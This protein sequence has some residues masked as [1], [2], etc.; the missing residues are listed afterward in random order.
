[1]Q[2]N[3]RAVYRWDSTHQIGPVRGFGFC[4]FRGRVHVCPAAGIPAKSAGTFPYGDD[5]ASRWLA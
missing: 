3:K 2:A 5:V 4:P 1:M